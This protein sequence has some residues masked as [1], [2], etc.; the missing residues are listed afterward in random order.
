MAVQEQLKVPDKTLCRR[1]PGSNVFRLEFINVRD[2]KV[3]GVSSLVTPRSIGIK[4]AQELI[5]LDQL[6]D[7]VVPV[8]SIN[9]PIPHVQELGALTILPAELRLEV[10]GNFQSSI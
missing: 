2:I 1:Q 7:R 10:L 5:N 8:S 4:S 3:L 6:F 9:G